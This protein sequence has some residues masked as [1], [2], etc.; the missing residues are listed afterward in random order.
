MIKNVEYVANQRTLIKVKTDKGNFCIGYKDIRPYW[1]YAS[2]DDFEGG[3]A[4]ISS[5]SDYLIF[6]MLT[7]GGQGGVVCV[8]DCNENKLIHISEGSHVITATVANNKVYKLHNVSCWGVASH[9]NVS[10]SPLGTMNAWDEGTYLYADTPTEI[11]DFY[12]AVEKAKIIVENERI[13]IQF[14]DQDVLF[15][16][17]ESKATAMNEKF[18]KYYGSPDETKEEAK[19]R[20]EKLI[21]GMLL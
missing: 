17:D 14:E 4:T 5:D 6:T 3:S 13:S 18:S 21:A 7:A 16:A 20:K 2:S 12:N 15:T 8:W 1:D 9:L 11:K 19:I 10:T